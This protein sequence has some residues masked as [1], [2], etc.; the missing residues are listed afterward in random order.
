VS[1][2]NGLP[3]G[4]GGLARYGW[5]QEDGL[6]G[7]VWGTGRP[8]IAVG[9]L[10]HANEPLGSAVAAAVEGYPDGFGSIALVGPIDPPPPSYR[11][12]LP[13]D[14]VAFARRGFL[15]RTRDQ[16]EFAHCAEPAT[17]AQHRAAELRARLSALSPDAFVL[18]HNDPR[19]HTPY[20]YANRAWPEVERHLR[21]DLGG[22]FPDAGPPPAPWTRLIDEYTYAFF[23]CDRIGVADT[24]SAGL[25]IERELGI[26]TLTIELPMFSWGAAEQARQG[27]GDLLG[28]WISAG[29]VDSG[30]RASMV[31]QI[32]RLLAGQRVAMVRPSVSSRVVWAVVAG[33]RESLATGRP[34]RPADTGQAERAEREEI[35]DAAYAI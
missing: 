27:F 24:E 32:T 13:C 15:Q 1:G 35:R 9:L 20:L 6:T 8:L 28:R 11:F 22:C 31:R 4:S 2:D 30:D 5:A 25:Y 7:R 26:P 19:A 34:P 33:L 17:P 10:P 16:V 29:G 3:P 14:P 18:V 23:P 12:Q 21:D